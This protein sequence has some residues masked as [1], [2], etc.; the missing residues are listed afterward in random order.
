MR[1]GGW[2]AVV[3]YCLIGLFIFAALAGAPEAAHHG[4]APAMHH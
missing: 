3:F 4:A 2:G 1:E